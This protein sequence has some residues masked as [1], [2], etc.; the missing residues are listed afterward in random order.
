MLPFKDEI[1]ADFNTILDQI[2][3]WSLFEVHR[4]R[5]ALGKLVDDPSRNEWR[6]QDPS[7]TMLS[8]SAQ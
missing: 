3:P 2:E 5:S 8:L 4:L 7:A 1:M 6:F